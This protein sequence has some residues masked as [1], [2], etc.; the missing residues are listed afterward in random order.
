MGLLS[1][2]DFHEQV[3]SGAVTSGTEIEYRLYSWGEIYA[4]FQGDR[5][6]SLAAR[7]ILPDFPFKIF[8]SSTPYDAPVPQKLCLTFRAP[9]EVKADTKVVHTSGIFPHEIAEEFAAFLSV[10]TRRRVFV[11]KQTRSDGLPIEMEGGPY[12]RTYLQEPQRLKEIDRAHIKALLRNLRAIDRRIANSFVL[13]MRLYHAA[14]EML[15]TA[16]EFSYLFLVTSLESISSAVNKAYRPADEE[17]FLDSRHPGW[18]KIHDALPNERRSEFIEL[19][20]ANETFTFRKLEK[21]VKDY[22][23]D[24]FWSET[25][26]DAKPHRMEVVFGQTSDEF[27]RKRLLRLAGWMEEYEKIDRNSLGKALRNVYDARSKL[28]HEG[29]RLPESIVVGHYPGIPVEALDEMM[30]AFQKTRDQ[31]PEQQSGSPSLQEPVRSSETE[32]PIFRLDVPPLLTFE[33]LVSCTLTNYLAVTAES[34]R[35]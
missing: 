21:F 27:E 35:R 29:V 26:D 31:K 1:A 34:E 9:H 16:P 23:P 2:L 14:I 28:I 32:S 7:F 18:E 30:Q 3:E 24:S 17:T 15:Y 11:G 4:P 19:L 33:R 5:E 10:V 6:H 25:C 12:V 13:A 8:S 22:L 20:F